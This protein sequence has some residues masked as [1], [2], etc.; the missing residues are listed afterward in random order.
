MFFN[1]SHGRPSGDCLICA[2]N[3]AASAVN[4][5]TSEV[6]AASREANRNA[7]STQQALREQKTRIQ[8]MCQEMRTAAEQQRQLLNKRPEPSMTA[9]RE[10]HTTR[11]ALS[12]GLDPAMFLHEARAREQRQISAAQGALGEAMDRYNAARAVREGISVGV[13]S[14]LPAALIRIGWVAVFVV[15]S[16]IVTDP[17]GVLPAL[18]LGSAAGVGWIV[19]K[20][21]G[22]E[23]ISRSPGI[24][25]PPPIWS[26]A[27]AA[28]T[29]VAWVS[30]ATVGDIED[31]F[32]LF[33]SAGLFYVP[34]T[35]VL[36]S[37]FKKK[38]PLVQEADIRLGQA[39]GTVID[40]REQLAHANQ[41]PAVKHGLVSAPS[42]SG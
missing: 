17:V 31:S 6:S 14:G 32:L 22:M 40:A 7:Q 16:F 39:T 11:E 33:F 3:E 18:L 28:A 30:V 9:H 1:C 26:M 21:S 29:G 4:S 42:H 24:P 35:F 41:H 37:F 27:G 12:Y 5:V 23:G 10:A 34:I 15:I 25:L 38:S 13:V 19:H 20:R 36:R 8:H 2:T